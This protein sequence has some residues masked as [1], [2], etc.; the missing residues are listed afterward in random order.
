MK[1][2]FEKQMNEHQLLETQRIFLENANKRWNIKCGGI[3]S[4]KK[5]SNYKYLIPKRIKELKKK[6]GS[7]LLLSHRYSKGI[8]DEVKVNWGCPVVYEY[9]AENKN[10]NLINILRSENFKYIYGE[11]IEIWNKD[12][13]FEVKEN[14]ERNDGIF[15]GEFTDSNVEQWLLDFIQN[16]K[17]LFLQHYDTMDNHFVKERVVENSKDI[18]TGR[19]FEDIT[20]GANY[21]LL[22]NYITVIKWEMLKLG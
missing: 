1:D 8:L 11:H 16:E 20:K 22:K 21:E 15:D 12:V 9:N 4:G 7:V 13:F 5:Y 18:C 6:D 10:Q 3:F 17:N 2:K 14:I 19:Q